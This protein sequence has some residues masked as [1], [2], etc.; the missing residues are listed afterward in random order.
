MA[1]LDG[2][3]WL[4]LA[5]PFV[6]S[7]MAMVVY[8]LPAGKPLVFARSACRQCG[9]TLGV[10]DL[11]PILSWL[12]LRG[13]CR[14]CGAAVGAL[15]PLIEVGAL[16]VAL[17]SAA[18]LPAGLAWA[19]CL[20][21]WTL[22]T[23]AVIDVRHLILPDLLT[24]SLTAAGLLTAWIIDP[25]RVAEHLIGAAA[26]FLVFVAIGA[27]YRAV[28]GRDG[29]GGGDA[30]LAA[31]A[32]AWV[33]WQGLPGVVLIA[34]LTGLLAAIAARL[35]GHAV[36]RDTA[37]PFGAFLAAGTWIVWLYGPLVPG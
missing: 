25:S 33:A 28:R 5:A 29:L 35:S 26:G 20:L 18:V 36:G 21:G 30:K 34:A 16:G 32:G 10:L 23:L 13:R 7:F 31:A 22:L 11:V 9:H 6:G 2:S 19:G 14:H 4:L 12:A 8:R 37:L 24:L 1:R 17:W 27:A 15:Y 3:L